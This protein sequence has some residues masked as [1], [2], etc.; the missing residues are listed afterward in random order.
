MTPYKLLPDSPIYGAAV[1]KLIWDNCEYGNFTNE[2]SIDQA[3][4]E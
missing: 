2:F 1:N 3:S 4:F